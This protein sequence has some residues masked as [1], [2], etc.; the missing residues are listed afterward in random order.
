M[1]SN[2][3]RVEFLPGTLNIHIFNGCFSWM[4]PNLYLKNCC[5]PNIH[6]KNG[7]LGFQVFRYFF[8]LRSA[9]ITTR[10]VR[11]TAEM[12][13]RIKKKTIRWAAWPPKK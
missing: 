11:E 12:E 6:S 7:C 10:I 4:L 9:I 1:I 5:S 3:T 8:L 13:A 2:E